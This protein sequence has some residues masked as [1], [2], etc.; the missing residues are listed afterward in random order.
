MDARTCPACDA[1]L[2][3]A[4]RACPSCG[5]AAPGVAS[6]GRSALWLWIGL[7]LAAFVILVGAAVVLVFLLPKLGGARQRMQVLQA[8]ADA[9]ELAAAAEEFA[10]ANDAHP[11]TLAVLLTPDAHGQRYL[12]RDALPKDPWGR[13][14]A[15]DPP[16]PGANAFARVWSLGED[17]VSGTGDDVDSRLLEPND[18]EP[19]EQAR[20][21]VE[22]LVDALEE[23]RRRHGRYP[24]TLAELATPDAAGERSLDSVPKDPWGRS[25]LYLPPPLSGERG[26]RV[27]SL[28]ADGRPG[29]DD[30]YG[31]SAGER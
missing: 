21:D 15:Y 4:A 5:I 13:D 26:P 31:T 24:A 25:Y 3:P 23:Q 20:R 10:R 30:V 11:D 28:G 22:A 6:G 18:R 7:A 17:G 14:Y 8:H 27:W 2:A 9:M 12:E 1:P 19:P 16:P 29:N